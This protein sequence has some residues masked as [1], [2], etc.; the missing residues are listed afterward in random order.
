MRFTGM[1]AVAAV[2]VILACATTAQADERKFTYSYEAKTLPQGS[3]EFEQ[4]ATLRAKREIGKIWFVDLREE[5]EYGVTDR[6]NIA[7]YFNWEIES[8]RDVPGVK[9][10]TEGEFETISLEFKYKLTD[11]SADIVGL[12]A[13]AEVA[14]GPEE[15]ELELKAIVSKQIGKFT[16]A[17]N[18]IVEFER[19]EESKGDWERESMLTHTFGASMEVAKGWAIGAEAVVRTE[20]ERNFHEQENIHTYSDTWWATLTFLTLTRD[21]D[22]FEKY[23]VRLIVG[24]NF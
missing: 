20:F 15:Q 21:P 8:I 14:W 23:E 1:S 19:E 3:W 11:P 7:F 4:W 16:F 10:E 22:D 2:A 17:Y 24:I 18:F 12:L 13:Y 9:D 5:L 6:F